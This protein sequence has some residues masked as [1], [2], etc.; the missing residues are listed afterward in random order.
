MKT[1]IPQSPAQAV[2]T[3]QLNV[4]TFTVSL[5][6]GRARTAWKPNSKMFFLPHEIKRLSLSLII[7]SL[8]LN[9]DIVPDFLSLSSVSKG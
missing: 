5:S 9:S 6:E 7:F 2:S 4:L 8:L 3:C 1:K